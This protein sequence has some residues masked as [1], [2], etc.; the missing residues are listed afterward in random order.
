MKEDTPLVQCTLEREEN[1]SLHTLVVWLD[2]TQVKLNANIL[3]SDPFEKGCPKEWW[4]IKRIGSVKIPYGKLADKN[5]TTIW[6][7]AINQMRGNK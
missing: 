3:V 1:E 7:V 2:S 4:T 5:R 6:D